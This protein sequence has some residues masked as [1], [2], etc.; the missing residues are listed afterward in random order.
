MA[1]DIFDADKRVPRSV[2]MAGIAGELVCTKPF[3]S[4]P[5][6]FNGEDGAEKYESSYFSQFGRGTWCQGDYVQRLPDTGGLV[7]L[8][9]S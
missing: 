3:P 1:V 7:M 2:E 8:G 9:R 4:Q 6:Q 5:L